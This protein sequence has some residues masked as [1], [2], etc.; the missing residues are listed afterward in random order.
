MCGWGRDLCAAIIVVS[1]LSSAANADS[2]VQTFNMPVTPTDIGGLTGTGTF[3]Y[4]QSSGAPLGATL[5]S[6][7]L[8]IS[9][10]ETIQ[11]LTV[12]NND[13]NNP[14]TFAYLSYAQVTPVGTAPAADKTALNT[15][16]FLNGG[17]NGDIDL[18]DTGNVLYG[19]SGSVIYAPPTL[20]GT[21]DSLLV[22]A[23][24][25]VPYDTTGSFTLGFTTQTFQS[26]VGGGGNGQ[27]NQVTD[28]IGTVQVIYNYDPPIVPE[29]ASIALI[30]CGLMGL[31]V[32]R[33][34]RS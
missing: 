34:A 21:V 9:V 31:V 17:V 11:S 25:I 29:P 15:A 1:A 12:S 18:I 19:P 32:R 22:N 2:I 26:F 27:S 7:E 3:D 8:R 16:L 20:T 28:A 23:A 5:T 6:V 4:F 14:Q 30:G 10:A 33:R 24:S 13:P